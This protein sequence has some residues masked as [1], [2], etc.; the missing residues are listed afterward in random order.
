MLG[1]ARR[2]GA[3]LLATQVKYTEIQINPQ[4]EDYRAQLIQLVLEAVTTKGKESLK[5]YADYQRIHNINTRIMRIFN[6]YGPRMRQM[7]E[8]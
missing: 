3:D 1:L 7:M 8:E 2:V 4:T 5:H 6:T